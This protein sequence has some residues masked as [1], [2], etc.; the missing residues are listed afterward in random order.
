MLFQRQFSVLVKNASV[1]IHAGCLFHILSRAIANHILLFITH[2]LM[3]IWEPS[4]RVSLAHPISFCIRVG[5]PFAVH[6][7]AKNQEC[8]K[9]F[10]HCSTIKFYR[11]V[12]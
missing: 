9:P 8:V 1:I 7:H 12:Q 10:D 11:N 3:I 5:G 2:L 6:V 4:S